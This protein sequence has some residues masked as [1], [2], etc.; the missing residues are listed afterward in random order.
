MSTLTHQE[1]LLNEDKDPSVQQLE[2]K[3]GGGAAQT[4]GG[5]PH[6]AQSDISKMKT[7]NDGSFKR[8]AA[9]FRN[10]IQ[11]HGEFAPEKGKCLC[12]SSCS[13]RTD[14]ESRTLPPLCIIRLPYVHAYIFWER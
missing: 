4:S 14:R 3:T 1:R 9:S 13:L 10:F 11:E 5:K 6:E 12:L 8:K 2:Q 7:E